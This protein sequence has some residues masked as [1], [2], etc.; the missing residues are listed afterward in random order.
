MMIC[1]SELLPARAARDQPLTYSQCF[2]GGRPVE[3]TLDQI[4]VLVTARLWRFKSSHPHAF[5]TYSLVFVWRMR[6]HRKAPSLLFNHFL[7][8]RSLRRTRLWRFCADAASSR[9][10]QTPLIGE[11]VYGV[12]STIPRRI[13]DNQRHSNRSRVPRQSAVFFELPKSSLAPAASR[14]TCTENFSSDPAECFPRA[15]VS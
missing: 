5:S 13:G 15:R 7:V 2:S 3:N 1:H 11:P 9:A 10:V 12:N 8:Q 14:S 6:L 4:Q